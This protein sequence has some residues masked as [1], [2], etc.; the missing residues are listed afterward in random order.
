[1][2]SETVRDTAS[3]QVCHRSSPLRETRATA[4]LLGHGGTYKGSAT[5]VVRVRRQHAVELWHTATTGRSWRAPS[6]GHWRSHSLQAGEGTHNFLFLHSIW[7]RQRVETS[8]SLLD[9]PS[10]VRPKN[11]P[12]LR[13]PLVR[14]LTEPFGA[15]L[16]GSTPALYFNN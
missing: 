15:Q 4:C 7:P 16:P 3:F 8:T 13:R 14:L 9:H 11:S 6:D 2:E 10:G 1:M 12:A 5:L